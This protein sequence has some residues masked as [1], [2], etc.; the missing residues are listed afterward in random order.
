MNIRTVAPVDRE[1][2][3]HLWQGYLDFYETALDARISETTWRRLLDQNEPLYGLVAVDGADR[4]IG[5]VNYVL[6]ANTWT[7]K[8]VCYLEDLFV[9]ASARGQGAGRALIEAVID[10][11]K[12]QGWHRVYWQTKQ[13]NATARALYDKIAPVTDWV[14]YDVNVTT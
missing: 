5:L 2:W 8:P 13:G 11:A 6:H 9:D 10:L 14:R 12:T 1:S 3:F 4:V 7:E